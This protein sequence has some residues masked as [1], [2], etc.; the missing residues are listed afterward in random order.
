MKNKQMILKMKKYN[1]NKIMKIK[2]IY[3]KKI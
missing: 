3:N 2:N 1:K